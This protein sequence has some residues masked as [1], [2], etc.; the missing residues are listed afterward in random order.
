MR[1]SSLLPVAG[2]AALFV[3]G[4]NEARR[5]AAAGPPEARRSVHRTAPAR[6]IAGCLLLA[7]PRALGEVIGAD[8]SPV[9]ES[10]WLVR[11]VA[12]RD[13]VLGVAGLAVSRSY[14]ESRGWLF[15]Q[16]LVDGAEALVVLGAVRRGELEPMRGLAFAAAEVGSAA[17]AVGLLAH[18]GEP[19]AE[20]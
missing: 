6:V 2:G 5:L 14:E 11:M 16:S 12:V 18:S 1:R 17:V 20:P 10:N 4:I 7:R 9:S 3:L 19:L 15:A 13:L 8:F